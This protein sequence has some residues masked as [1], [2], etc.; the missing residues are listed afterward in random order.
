MTITPLS[1][2][3]TVDYKPPDTSTST[4]KAEADD[5][6]WIVL[7]LK[8][9]Y[10]L[11]SIS[12]PDHQQLVAAKLHS[13]LSEYTTLTVH[14]AIQDSIDH[15]SKMRKLVAGIDM[16]Y[17]RFKTSRFAVI[18]FGSVVS[19]YKD[20]AILSTINHIINFTDMEASFVGQ[21]LFSER[22]ADEYAAIM[23]DN[24]ELDMEYSY[25]PYLSDM[26]LSSKS[27]YSATV[28]PI[29]LSYLQDLSD[30]ES[31]VKQE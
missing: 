15:G 8:G 17:Y 26:E 12:R 10:R 25:M 2:F 18:R 9:I 29:I 23:E 14:Y 31:P 16:F 24:N 20:C 13:V 4:E 5:D 30:R 19:R 28:N 7:I 21:W 11:K 22:A 3:K 6:I 1:L 27:P